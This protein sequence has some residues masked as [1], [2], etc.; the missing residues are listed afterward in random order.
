[1]LKSILSLMG[2]SLCFIRIRSGRIEDLMA[3]KASEEMAGKFMAIEKIFK[4]VAS[5]DLVNREV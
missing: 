3:T 2:M 1:M 5:G 4:P